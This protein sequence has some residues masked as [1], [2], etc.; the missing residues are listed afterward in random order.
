MPIDYALYL[1]SGPKRRKTMVHVIELLGCVATGTTTEETVAATPEAIR[2]YLRFLHRCGEGV[3]PE[4]PFTTHIE[5]HITEGSWLGNGSPYLMFAP[6]YEPLS[7]EDVTTFTR[8]FRE[9]RDLLAGWADEQTADSL[10]AD[11]KAG[12]KNRAILLHL[13]G[14]AGN[15]ASPLLGGI[16][17]NSK[18]VTA[19][20]RGELTLPD[21]LRQ[22]EALISDVLRAS[23]EQQRSEVI[24]RGQITRSLRKAIRR[25]LE[26]DWEHIAELSRR[27]GGPDI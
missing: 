16:P 14:A 1:E 4:A 18:V 20:T 10:D 2:A 23:T 5:E 27:P 6:D 15:Y 25:T 13:L 22:S 12:R 19:T 26:H 17:G 11:T 9:M 21:G 3:D 7:Q 24:T 8:R